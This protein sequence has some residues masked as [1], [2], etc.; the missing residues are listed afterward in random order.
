MPAVSLAD[1]P[2]LITGASSGIGLATARLC[3]AAGMPVLLVARRTEKLLSAVEA[4]RASGGRADAAPCDVADPQQCASAVSRCL[5]EFGGIYAVFANAGYGFEAP[6]HECSEE[7]LRDIF[8]VNF[9]GSLNIVRPALERMLAAKSGHVLFCASC[10]SK[11]GTP[12]YGH[13]SATKAAQ[14]HFGRAMRHELAPFGVH[15]STVHPIGTRTEFFDQAQ[16]RSPDVRVTPRTSETFMQPPDRVAKAVLACLKKPRGEVWTSTPTRLLLG[17][18]T[19]F[20]GLADWGLR[21][22]FEA[23][24][25]AR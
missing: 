2:I 20:P 8:E 12:R 13:Y 19:M 18:A 24:R 25:K 15:V 14:D 7:Q 9:W 22:A 6:I 17:I 1:K 11:I 3:A 16:Q 5:D 4:I 10:L 23:R 21:R